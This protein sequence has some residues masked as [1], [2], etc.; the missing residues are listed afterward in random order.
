MFV[1]FWLVFWIEMIQTKTKRHVS[2]DGT[3]REYN[4]NTHKWIVIEKQN[5]SSSSSDTKKPILAIEGHIFPLHEYFPYLN[6]NILITNNYLLNNFK[7]SLKINDKSIFIGS[8]INNNIK[9][10]NEQYFGDTGK[11]I[12]DTS[13]HII[14]MLEFNTL[15]K[16]GNYSQIVWN[17]F[18]FVTNDFQNDFENDFSKDF[19]TC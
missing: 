14:K 19:L 1:L 5:N 9:Y 15:H 6:N 7:S 11:I 10:S 18:H 13:I 2:K 8:F 3:V 17:F 12:W 4:F 16:K